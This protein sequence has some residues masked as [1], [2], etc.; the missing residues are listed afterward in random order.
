MQIRTIEKLSEHREMTPEGYLLCRGAALART[1]VMR[2]LAEDVDPEIMEGSNSRE[3]LLYRDDGEVFDR[4]AMASF[5]GK[6]FTLDHPED[7]VDPENWQELARGVVMN[8]RRGEGFESD[9]LLA[10]ILITDAEAIEA[11][12]KGLVELSCGYDSRLEKIRPGVGRQTHIRGNH[13]ALVER[14]RAG[15]RCRINDKKEDDKMAEKNAK[16]Q[17]AGNIQKKTGFV[18]RLR[19]LLKDAEA[20]EAKA[21]EEITADEEPA[22]QTATDNDLAASLEEIKLMLRTLVEGLKPAA[23]EETPAADEEPDKT[24][25]EEPDKTTDGEG[26]DDEETPASD[27]DEGEPKKDSL[28]KRLCDSKTAKAAQRLGLSGAREGDSLDAVQR[29]ALSIAMR[30][31]ETSAIVRDIIGDVPLSRANPAAVRAAFYAVSAISA[32]SASKNVAKSLTDSG[33]KQSGPMT[34]AQLNQINQEFYGGKK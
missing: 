16:K 33:R 24:A 12:E 28:P 18:D 31:S 32:K 17:P 34:P 23:D 3:A 9:L 5:E 8:V 26:C 4:E 21:D 29:G 30:D 20:E 19:R 22:A 15:G 1:G 27:E 13:V 7:D 6:P 25:D 14:G 10:D 11:V 2:Y